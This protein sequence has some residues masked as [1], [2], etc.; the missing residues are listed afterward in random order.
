M[1]D[2]GGKGL[3]RISL[4]DLEGLESALV[5][6]TLSAPVSEAS[7]RASGFVAG[8]ADIAAALRDV[9]RAG[10]IAAVR[11][12]LAER[13]H[14]A[15]P[16]LDLV[17]TGP[18]PKL[19]T[20][21]DTAIIVR[22]LFERARRNVLVGGF[23]FDH[24]EELFRPLH[25]AMRDHGVTATFFVDL[26]TRASSI[27]GAEAHA[28]DFI[29]RFFWKEWA[30]GDPKPEVY[31]DP[32]TAMPGPPWVSLHAKC[33]VVDDEVALVTSANFTDRGQTRNIE[34][35]VRIEDPAFAGQIAAQWRGLISTGAVKKHLG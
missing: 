22:Q 17:W 4:D 28:T 5:R 31:Y 24:G 8:A 7:L 2:R 14:R 29:D 10:A 33:V 3:S 12:V 34:L 23:R 26:A 35:G 18:E 6:G 1:H 20:S 15:P 27:E 9:D 16:R 19:S 30:F 13:R 21:R 11:V 32:R 25:A